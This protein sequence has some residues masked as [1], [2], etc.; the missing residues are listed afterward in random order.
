[1]HHFALCLKESYIINIAIGAIHRLSNALNTLHLTHNV[2]AYIEP[3][4]VHKTYVILLKQSELLFS[5]SI[6]NSSQVS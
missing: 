3:S 5:S 1:M 2:S 6:L 4:G